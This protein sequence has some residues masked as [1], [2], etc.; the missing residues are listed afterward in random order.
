MRYSSLQPLALGLLLTAGGFYGCKTSQKPAQTTQAAAPATTSASAPVGVEKPK[1]RILVF[2]KTAAF[3]HTSIPSG[4]AALQKLGQE[5]GFEVDTTKNATLFTEDNL[6]KYQAVIFLS[7]TGNVLDPDQQ[8]AFERYIQA[9]GGYVGIHAATD[10]EYNWPWYNKLAGAYFASHPRQQNAGID[11]LDKKHPS[12]SFL[13]DRWERYDELYNFKNINPDVKVLMNLDEDSYE[14]GT[15]GSN[16]PFAWY[17]DY[18]GGRAFYTAGGHT[19]ES[20]SEPLFLKHL[21]G[22]IQYAMG[23]GKLDFAKAYSVKTPEENRFVKTVLSND[24][25]EPMELAVAPDGRVFFVERAGKFYQYDPKTQQTRLVYDFPVKAVEKYLNGLLGMT[26]DPNFKQNHYLYFFYTIQD[27]EQ[28]KQ[29]IARFVMGDD[30]VLDVASE[31][32]IIEFPIDLEVSAHT[33]GSMAWDAKGNLFISTGDNTVP[34]ESSG[35]APIDQRPNRLTFDAE[36]SAGNPNDLRGKILRIHVEADGSYTIPE[37]NLFAKGT[38]GTRPEIYVMGCRNPYRISVDPLTGYVYWGE[39]GPDSGVDGPQGPRGYDEFNQAKKPG[40]F[41]WPYFVGD[42]KPYKEY[43]F[44]TKAVGKEFDVNGPTN[45][46]PYNTGAKTLPPAQKAMI[47][48]PYNRSAE[49]PELGESGRCAMGGPVYHFDPNL[50]SD[51]KLPAYYD[52]AVFFYDWMR[53]WVFAV[54][55]DEN[56]NYKRLE[57]FMPTRGDFR[58]PVDMEMGPEGA[59]YML[60]YGSVYGIDNEDARL[61]KIEYNAGNRAPVAKI[62]AKDTIGLAPLKVAFSSAK[63]YDFDEEDKLTYEW[64]FEGKSV[65]SREANPTHIFEKDGIYQ[66]VLKVTDPTGLSSYDTLEVKVGNTLPQ[67]AIATP[68][69]NSSFFFPTQT[70]L[71]Y[72]VNVKDNEDKVI[73]KKKVKVSLNYIPKVAGGNESQMGHQQITGTFNLGK[74][75]MEGS[76]CKACHQINKKSVGPAFMEVSKRYRGD[77][78]ALTRLAN[79]VITGGGGVWGEHAMNAHPQLAREEATE[80]VKYVLSLSNQQPDVRLPEKGTATL[81]EHV[82]KPQE[83]RYILT[84]SYTDKGGSIKPLTSSETLVLRPNRV[85]AT[86]VDMV[87]NINRQ[88]K[89]L[90]SIHNRSYF[91]LKNI[92]L[93]GIKQLTYRYASKDKDAMIEVHVDSPKGQVISTLNYK[94][95]GNW[96]TFQEVVSPI[97]NPGGK[98]DLYFVFVKKDK[99]NDNLFSLDWVEFGK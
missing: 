75:L 22:G 80:I 45:N 32:P 28:T 1:P 62:T 91:V 41:G 3:Y 46:S 10:T 81:K 21:L 24:L 89:R 64:Q 34:F 96:N 15:N 93:T 38:P 36:R 40:N 49:F 7:T 18:D 48:Y 43:N 97:L 79:K 54:R 25:N 42:N 70:P 13:P 5:N 68:G 31:K 16:H 86:G 84:A 39:I 50:A 33:G 85:D 59:I 82:G 11:V 37:G 52:K 65:A 35:F 12:T 53:N 55:L 51:V 73:D 94:A 69:G 58:R 47:W 87:S 26:I 61:V 77:K 23:D 95:T 56:Y 9:G 88:G 2:S 92:D 57:A 4:I 63:S 67:V 44:E 20:F 76:D 90:G 83:G 66:T 17:H 78:G 98:H 74:S 60:E 27:G 30:G 99:P 29:R 72:E 71:K 6:K 19:N 14:G 8:V